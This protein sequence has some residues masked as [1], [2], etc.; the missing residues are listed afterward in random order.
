M[1]LTSVT[2]WL[3]CREGVAKSPCRCGSVFEIYNFTVYT[4]IHAICCNSQKEIADKFLD[5]YG[6]ELEQLGCNAY[7]YAEIGGSWVRITD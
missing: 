4:P 1:W 3:F 7:L 5:E 2:V 6:G